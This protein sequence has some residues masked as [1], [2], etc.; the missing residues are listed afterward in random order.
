MDKTL[1]EYITSEEN[2]WLTTDVQLTDSKSWNMHDH[3]ERCFNV[4]NG[5]FHQGKND[6]LR[7]YNDIVTPIIDVAFR[8]EGFDVKD[9]IPYVNQAKQAHKSFLIKKYHPQWA[10][11][12]KIDT[13]IDDVVES[14]IIYDLVLMKKPAKGKAP[15][16]V[17]LQTI[18]FCDQTDVLAGPIAFKHQ[19][20]QQDL[21]AMKGVW[22]ENKI[23]ELIVMSSFVKEGQTT[24]TQT[25]KTPSKYIKIYEIH[26][27]LPEAWIK[28]G[29]SKYKFIPQMHIVGFYDTKDGKQGITLFSG[30]SKPVRK[31]FKALKIDRVRSFGRACGRSIVERLFEP[32]T[33]TNYDGIRLKEIL[34]GAALSLFQ[35]AS[36]KVHGQKLSS[37]KTNTILEIEDGKPVTKIDTYTGANANE[38]SGHQDK[39]AQSARALGAASEASLGVNPTAGTPFALQNLIVQQGEGIHEYRRGKI[40]TFFADE[41]YKDWFL[42]MMVSDLKKGV[43][44]N[45]ELS[46]DEMLQIGDAIAKNS[47]AQQIIDNIITTGKVPTVEEKDTL[48]EQMKEL[49]VKSDNRKFFEIVKEDMDG[50]PVAV[51][52]NVAGK[53]RYMAQNADRLS[54]LISNILQNPQ[55]F[56]QIPGLAKAYNELLEESGMS[57]IDFSGFIKETQQTQL[58]K[59]TVKSPITPDQMEAEQSL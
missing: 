18:A 12:N 4:S 22:D 13:F 32:Q 35:S 9:I 46:L 41:L 55:A 5:W 27:D 45:E 21:S 48:V 49:F 54:K 28:E 56:A 30:E 17:S 20:S 15:E 16:V 39:L 26:G 2:A 57:A 3:I 58:P 34:D 51:K 36:N 31:T 42:E 11:T 8:T 47:A 1:H 33:W 29:G 38:F 52:V 6:G 37:L 59:A 43:I 24:A 10:R 23:D 7:P 44:F 53:Q 19:Y 50:I 14:S 40:A 25:Q